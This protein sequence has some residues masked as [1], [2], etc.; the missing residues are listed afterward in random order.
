VEDDQDIRESL[1]SLL[2]FDFGSVRTAFDGTSALAAL[3]KEMPDV[4]LIDIGL[5]G[6]SGYDLARTI[7]QR[8]PEA[9]LRLIALTGYGRPSDRQSALEAGFDAHLTKPVHT[10]ELIRMLHEL[11][12]SEP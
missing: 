4:A 9:P 3:A 11:P 1:S 7:R 8:Y 10:R 12:T 5:P 2:S 6:M